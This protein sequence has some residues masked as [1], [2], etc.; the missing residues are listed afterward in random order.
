MRLPFLLTPKK[1]NS[2][3]VKHEATDG[4]KGWLELLLVAGKEP[5]RAP[6][7]EGIG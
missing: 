4:S 7:E 2:K 5:E 3:Y 6:G 1:P